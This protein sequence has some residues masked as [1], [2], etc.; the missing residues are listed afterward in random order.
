MRARAGRKLAPAAGR[1]AHEVTDEARGSGLA[2]GSTQSCRKTTDPNRRQV[3]VRTG[4][5]VRARLRSLGLTILAAD[6][7]A[8]GYSGFGRSPVTRTLA[9]RRQRQW[10]GEGDVSEQSEMSSIYYGAGSEWR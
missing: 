3:R 2:A 9:S 1:P 10:G 8:T 4:H 6:S 5:E 7:I